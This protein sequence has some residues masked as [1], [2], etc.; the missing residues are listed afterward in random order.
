MTCTKDFQQHGDNFRILQ[1]MIYATE[2]GYK[3][4]H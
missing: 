4:D 3:T 2:I 1:Q